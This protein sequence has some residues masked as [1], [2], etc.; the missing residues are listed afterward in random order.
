[1]QTIGEELSLDPKTIREALSQCRC[2][3]RVD[4]ELY[5]QLVE[6]KKQTDGLKVYAMTNIAKDD[7][8]RLKAVLPSWDLFDAE[9][10]SFG[11]GMI[12]PELGYYQH[13]IQNISLDN[14]A[15]AIFVDDKV[16]SECICLKC[17]R[18]SLTLWPYLL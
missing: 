13:V 4:H 16:V 14:P 6:I 17:V 3:L 2:T 10:T 5:A 12:K 7:F 8:Q 15:S 1:V 9:F 18:C 11:V